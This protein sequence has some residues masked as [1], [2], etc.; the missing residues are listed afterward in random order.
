MPHTRTS[1]KK[2]HP[3]VFAAALIRCA[4]AA[5]LLAGSPV[6]LSAA[7]A[8]RAEA[9]VLTCKVPGGTGF[10]FGATRQLA[11]T[12]ERAGQTEYYIAS[13][14]KF[15]VNVGVTG[16]SLIEWTV[17]APTPRLPPGALSGYF[18][19]ASDEVA[20]RTGL[21]AHS[22]IGGGAARQVA[23]QPPPPQAR[24]GPIAASG[25]AGLTLR[26]AR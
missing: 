20:R 24:Q 22:L 10:V 26:P 3:G 17:L 25:I 19:T 21:A 12:Y 5:G 6:G 9:G 2:S 8:G 11:C 4:A 7:E 1:W 18:A 13:I 23:L 16:L 14:S 15:G